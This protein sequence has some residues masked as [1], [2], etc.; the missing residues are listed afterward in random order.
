M[1][2]LHA[3]KTSKLLKRSLCVKALRPVF[4]IIDNDGK[5]LKKQNKRNKRDSLAIPLIS[6]HYR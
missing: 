3:I 4:D 2:C 6:I 1:F 5:I